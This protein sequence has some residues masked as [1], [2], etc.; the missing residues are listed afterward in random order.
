MDQRRA[1]KFRYSVHSA[2]RRWPEAG[3][4]VTLSV[5]PVVLDNTAIVRA[6]PRITRTRLT[7]AS[8]VTLPMAR[9]VSFAPGIIRPCLRLLIWIWGCIRFFAGGAFDV[10]LRRATVQR[11]AARLR[12][13][14]ED[15][16]PAA[17]K[18]GQQLSLR[19]DLLPYPYCA[20][21]SNILD[22]TEPVPV[23]DAI[24]VIERSF[25][26][27]L[28][29]LFESFDPEPIG[30][31]SLACVYQ[32][33][34]KSGEHVAV[35][36]RR[37]GID[38]LLSTD[39]RALD[40][41]LISA[42]LV[43]ILRPGFTNTLRSELR[44]TLLG[45]LNFRT[46]A[47]Y[48]DIFRRRSAKGTLNVTA[49]RVF[50]QFCTEEVLVAEF[51]SGIW[52]WELMGAVDRDDKEFLAKASEVGIEPKSLARRLAH[53]VHCE[54]LE[55]LF[56]HAD[57]HPANLVVLPNNRLCF[58][59]FGAV[60]RFSTKIRNA[61]REFHYH[62]RNEDV[63]RMVRCALTF[64]EPL[65][66]IDVDKFTNALEDIFFD[67][68]HATASHDAEWW[69]R[70]TAQNWLRYISVA[71]QFSVPV[72]RETMQFFRTTLLYDSIIM[73]LN[74]DLDFAGEYERYAEEAARVARR[75]VRR[76]VRKR[77]GG[78]TKMDYL[79]IEQLADTTNQFLFRFQRTIEDPIVGFRQ[80]VGKVAYF[81]SML[82]RISSVGIILL[83]IGIIAKILA[84]RWLGHDV[85][86]SE[87]F[88]F[89]SSKWWLQI[90]LLIFVLLLV[91]RL[92]VRV[93]DPEINT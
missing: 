19:A 22:N 81:V 31:A 44:A 51:V 46:E 2:L 69:E 89:L 8:E 9:T 84:G 18:L 43:T 87:L 68:V 60:G 48:T 38:R 88:E 10:F 58:I 36:V 30:S 82:L 27:P 62:M 12:R 1:R 20:E 75:R 55:N 45:E 34:L 5:E 26:R 37:P 78:A 11:R 25:A 49:P 90:P 21:L 63:G 17:V 64:V 67:W 39:L 41:L 56:F 74:K 91:R 57:P 6:M 14:F 71:R 50:F 33:R 3:M 53:T 65:P 7:A 72:N 23:S 83:G 80:M 4:P 54:I 13:I 92:L 79:R 47:R 93:S 61:W 77:L 16:G 24:A 70:S 40:W 35:K 29:E 28:N 15:T 76:Y 59:D 52:M 73:R 42:E 66:P 86:F 32:A 85:T